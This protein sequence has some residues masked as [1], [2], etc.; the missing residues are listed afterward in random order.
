MLRL[1]ALLVPRV[2]LVK[3]KQTQV[4]VVSTTLCTVPPRTAVRIIFASARHPGVP[5]RM[6]ANV[7]SAT[8]QTH[9]SSMGGILVPPAKTTKTFAFQILAFV[10]ATLAV[11]EEQNGS[12]LQTPSKLKRERSVGDK[13]FYTQIH[14]YY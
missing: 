3:S 12:P 1:S 14:K 7:N 6:A 4:I 11:A 8:L 5:T 10:V 13:F 2:T 9:A